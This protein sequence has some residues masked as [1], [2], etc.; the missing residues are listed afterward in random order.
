MKQSFETIQLLNRDDIDKNIKNFSFINFGL[1][2]VVVKLLTRQGLNTSVF[3][4]LRDSRFK[5]YKDALLG[6]VDTSLFQG[7]IYFN[8]YPNFVVSL[9]DET[10][11]QTLELDIE[12]SSYNMLEGT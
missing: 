3:L 1:V 5:I 4:C 9:T 8:C 2:Q 10:V 6:M 11:L 7:L 12:T